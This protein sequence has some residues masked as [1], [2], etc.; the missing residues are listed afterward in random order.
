M[1]YAAFWLHKRFPPIEWYVAVAYEQLQC[2]CSIWL[3][4][5]YA[6][7]VYILFQKYIFDRLIWFTQNLNKEQQLGT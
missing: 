1:E 2:W 4:F 6:S 7:I 5:N 3:F